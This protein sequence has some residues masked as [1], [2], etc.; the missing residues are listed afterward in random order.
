[1]AQYLRMDKHGI[2]SKAE[3]TEKS[4]SECFSFLLIE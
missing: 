1:M 3:K 4:K 2:H